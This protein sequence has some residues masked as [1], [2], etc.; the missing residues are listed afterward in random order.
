MINTA[1][2]T[3]PLPLVLPKHG[4]VISP[5]LFPTLLTGA[6]ALREA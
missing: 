3:S 4:G 6:V 1:S 2:F 5:A